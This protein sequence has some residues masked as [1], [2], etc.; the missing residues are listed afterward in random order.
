MLWIFDILDQYLCDIAF[1]VLYI[2]MTL[3]ILRVESFIDLEDTERY[4]RNPSTISKTNKV[5]A[6]DITC[7]CS[8]E[9][10][11]GVLIL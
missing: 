11:I 1:N 8:A 6:N 10:H 2:S 4:S 7:S 3:K 9:V 5:K